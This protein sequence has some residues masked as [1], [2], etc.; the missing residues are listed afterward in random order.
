[1][2]EIP[3]ISAFFAE[4]ERFQLPPP[5]KLLHGIGGHGEGHSVELDE[6]L[7]EVEIRDAWTLPADAKQ[8]RR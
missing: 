2:T 5:C 1:M 7:L 3:A 4:P 6:L 8:N